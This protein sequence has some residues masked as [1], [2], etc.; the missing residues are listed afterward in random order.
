LKLGILVNTDRHPIILKGLTQAALEKGHEVVI[1]VMDKGVK[2]LNKPAI[3]K[4]LKTPG[5][6]LTFCQHSAD[7]IG[8]KSNGIVKEANAGSQYDNACMTRE[9][10]RLIVL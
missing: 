9:V 8:I 5:I 4:L 3:V 1:F 7:V 6:S 10:D 2:L